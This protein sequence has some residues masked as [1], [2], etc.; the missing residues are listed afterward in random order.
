[1]IRRSAASRSA[2]RRSRSRRSIRR[3]MAMISILSMAVYRHDHP[4][5]LAIVLA[6]PLPTMEDCDTE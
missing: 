1:M 5:G 4:R 6:F 3:V 2:I